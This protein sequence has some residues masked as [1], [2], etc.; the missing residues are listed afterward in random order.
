[1]SVASVDQHK[2]HVAIR[3][4]SRA[5][6]L[7]NSS[8]AIASAARYVFKRFVFLASIPSKHENIC[9]HSILLT[10]VTFFFSWTLLFSFFFLFSIY[11]FWSTNTTVLFS[12]QPF[13]IL[14]DGATQHASSPSVWRNPHMEWMPPWTLSA[15]LHVRV[16]LS[17]STR[18]QQEKF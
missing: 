12:V 3:S 10:S 17:T 16:V 2:Y 1:M 11:F 8:P 15:I 4:A 18:E 7:S 13:S 14:E 9:I 6:K 5:L